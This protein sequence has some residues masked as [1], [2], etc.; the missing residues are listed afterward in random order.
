MTIRTFQAGDDAAQGR[1][2]NEAAGRPAAVQARDAGRAAP[3]ARGPDFDPGTRFFAWRGRPARRLRHVPR[4]RPRQLPLVPQGPRGGAP[5]RSSRPSSTRCAGA[6]IAG[7][8]AAYRAD[9]PAAARVLRRP[10]LRAR[11]ARWSIRHRHRR[12]ADAVGPL[13]SHIT[14]LTPADVPAVLRPGRAS[15]A[16]DDRRRARGS[17]SST[18]PTSRRRRCSCCAAAA[19]TSRRRRGAGRRVAGA[20]PTPAG[21]SRHALLPPRGVR[22]RGADPSASTACS[23]SSPP[24]RAT[25]RRCALDLLGHAT[26]RLQDTEVETLAAQ[27]PSDAPHLLRFYKRSS[28]GR[29]VSRVFERPL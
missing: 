20:T 6:A 15:C 9:W 3:P 1:I 5:S 24:T 28:A 21:R 17:T 14:P 25:C 11:R 8:F 12:H 7:A 13:A 27:V 23:A 10:R 16:A 19:A 22:H 2:Y 18:T 26:Q 29:G 4:Q